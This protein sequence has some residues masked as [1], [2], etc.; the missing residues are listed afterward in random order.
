MKVCLLAGEPSGAAIA[1]RLM[2]SLRRAIAPGHVQFCGVAGA[3]AVQQGLK[4]LFPADELAVMGFVE[5]IPHIWRTRQRIKQTV[6]FLKHE[7]P[8]VIVAIDSKGFNFRV[9]N[10]FKAFKEPH[11]RVYQ[12]V[13]PSVWS[14]KGR[15]ETPVKLN[16]LVDHMLCVLPFEPFYFRQARYA[17]TFVGHPAFEQTPLV[18]SVPGE[19]KAIDRHDEVA[20]KNIGMQPGHRMPK[21]NLPPPCDSADITRTYAI[22]QSFSKRAELG[23]LAVPD[24]ALTPH[25]VLEQLPQPPAGARQ[26][27]T[28]RRLE[29]CRG[30]LGLFPGSRVQEVE[31]SLSVL[32]ETVKELMKASPERIQRAV[33]P[34]TPNVETMVRNELARH[35]WPIP[36]KYCCSCWFTRCVV[37]IPQFELFLARIVRIPG[38]SIQSINHVRKQHNRLTKAIQSSHR[39]QSTSL[40]WTTTAGKGIPIAIRSSL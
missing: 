15:T 23:E 22:A 12:Y 10:D 33:L 9:L 16:D 32:N 8:D 27:M 17:C 4:S 14:M 20:D 24:M 36:S 2:V 37:G 1:A 31:K 7:R 19:P 11:Q 5:V 6:A 13:A 3:P 18:T 35:D 21:T 28:S 29:H 26:W 39:N 40:C 38:F 34:C 30:V 25:Q